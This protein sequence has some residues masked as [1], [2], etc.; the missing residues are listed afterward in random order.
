[1]IGY[2]SSLKN[3]RYCLC[4]MQRPSPSTACTRGS[5]AA[6][7]PNFVSPHLPNNS[8]QRAHFSVSHS[9]TLWLLEVSGTVIQIL[10]R[11]RIWWQNFN[12]PAATIFHKENGGILER[13]VWLESLISIRICSRDPGQH[14]PAKQRL[15]GVGMTYSPPLKN[16]QGCRQNVFWQRRSCYFGFRPHS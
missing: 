6:T 16:S 14:N 9:N 3:H 5:F 2:D 12:L 8:L 7:L 10:Q 4:Q 11:W 1:M 13:A 15:T